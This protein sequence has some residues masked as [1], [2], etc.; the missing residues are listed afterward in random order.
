M[1]KHAHFDQKIA[2]MAALVLDGI[3]QTDIDR[4]PGNTTLVRADTWKTIETFARS[5]PIPYSLSSPDNGIH[6]KSVEWVKSSEP[7]DNLVG[8]KCRIQLPTTDENHVIRVVCTSN[9]TLF[10]LLE[11]KSPVL[12]IKPDS[13]EPFGSTRMSIYMKYPDTHDNY[14]CVYYDEEEKAW[15]TKGIRR[16]EHSYHGYVKCETNHFGVFALLPVT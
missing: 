14:T 4:I 10:E 2:E 12:S 16:I 15:S 13:E 11:P 5:L 6:M 1:S 7:N 8:K 9:A 3:V